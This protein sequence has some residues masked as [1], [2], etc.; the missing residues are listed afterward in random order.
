MEISLIKQSCSLQVPPVQRCPGHLC[1]LIMM[2]Q[3]IFKTFTEFS[4]YFHG[5]F[6]DKTELF[7]TGTTS[8]EMPGHRGI[9]C[10]LIMMQQKIFKTFTEFSV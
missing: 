3:I 7:T 6:L 8:S 5:N 9:A 10:Q 1:Q 4:V 2:L